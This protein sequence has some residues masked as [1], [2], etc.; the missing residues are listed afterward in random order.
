MSPWLFNFYMDGVVREMDERLLG[1]GAKLKGRNKLSWEVNQL[2]FA[3]ATA[4]VADS[5]K[6]LRRSMNEFGRVCERCKLKVNLAKSKEMRCAMDGVVGTLE[7]CLNGEVLEEVESFKCTTTF[8]YAS[9]MFLI[10]RFSFL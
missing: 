6:K 4:L 7:I 9:T 1:R 5:E 3:N 8:L 10:N 2:L